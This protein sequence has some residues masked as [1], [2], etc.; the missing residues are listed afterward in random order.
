MARKRHLFLDSVPVLNISRLFLSCV[1]VG[2]SFSLLTMEAFAAESL[3]VQ[4]RRAYESGDYEGARMYLLEALPEA[5]N[6]AI[7]RVTILSNLSSVY[8]QLGDWRQAEETLT[9]AEILLNS[10]PNSTQKVYLFAQIQTLSGQ[11]AFLQ[12]H[13]DRALEAWKKAEESYRKSGQIQGQIESQVYQ[14][15]ALQELGFYR[16]A[17]KILLPLL[18]QVSSEDTRLLQGKVFHQLGNTIRVV[19]KVDDLED[20]HFWIPDR[21]RDKPQDYLQ[22]SEAFLRKS[23][24]IYQQVGQDRDRADILLDLGNTI[25]A[26]YYRFKDDLQRRYSFDDLLTDTKLQ[27]LMREQILLLDRAL[28]YYK[29]AQESHNI[30]FSSSEGNIPVKSL[31]QLQA[32]LNEIDL[33]LEVHNLYENGDF[34]GLENFTEIQNLVSLYS[35]IQQKSIIIEQNISRLSPSHNRLKIQ[36]KLAHQWIQFQQKAELEI[37]SSH[38]TQLL[39][40]IETTAQELENIRGLSYVKGY[41]GAWYEQ[42][43]NLAKARIFTERAI[44]LTE[45]IRAPE[46]RYLWEWQLGRILAAESVQ[47]PYKT[48]SAIAAYRSALNNL[49]RVR[50]DI[51]SLKNPDFR[52][53]FRDDVEPV[54]REFAALLLRT[55]TTSSISPKNN[56]KKVKNIIEPEK[57]KEAISVIERLQVAELED[58]LRCNL[59]QRSPASLEKYLQENSQSQTASIYPIFL[60]DRLHIILQLPGQSDPFH[61]TH[62]ELISRPEMYAKI[63]KLRD[64]IKQKKL[65][66]ND[67][68]IFSEIYQIFFGGIE[69]ILEENK[70]KNLVFVMDSDLRNIPLAALH[71]GQQY[72]IERYSLALNVGLE[73]EESQPFLFSETT[74]LAV[75]VSEKNL[76]SRALPYVEKELEFINDYFDRAEILLNQEFTVSTFTEKVQ[77]NPFTIVHLATH[78]VFS[79]NP[80]QTSIF[81]YQDPMSLNELS[82]L[83]LQQQEQ[84]KQAIELLVLSACQTAVGD[85]RAT[86]GIAGIATR[87]GAKSTLA[88]LF[89]VN[90]RLS[91]QLMQKFYQHLNTPN[92]SKAEAL[93]QAQL[94]L[95]KSGHRDYK[96]PFYWSPYILVGNWQ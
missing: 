82:Q 38:F 91:A 28:I 10:E 40:N 30:L 44:L 20:Y 37:D 14:T 29:K 59:Q 62:P 48:D 54:Y 3:M 26:Q 83:L 25:F 22:I 74:I 42:Q 2:M 79:S 32:Q 19:G 94:T 35:K 27:G 57:A 46:I 17:L 39:Q 34:K 12:G 77:E 7:E 23:E 76:E 67:N 15:I 55:P 89:S 85:R 58:Y 72:L 64:A 1:L 49:D 4:G 18:P 88:T 36:L 69:T 84:Q 75:G 95:L 65:A 9:R 21:D 52:F 71:N 6:N 92:I 41:W 33:I 93:R 78:G 45:E 8:Q 11:L 50:E 16:E 47:K 73:I 87:S 61:Y 13:S 60:E 63:D 90:D 24:E 5:E 68:P 56:G 70:V 31:T 80:E 51:I 43:G 96:K 53:L 86:L 66:N 81:A